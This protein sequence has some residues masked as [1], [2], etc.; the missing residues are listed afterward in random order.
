[1]DGKDDADLQ[2]ALIQELAAGRR[3]SKIPLKLEALAG[4]DANH[5]ADQR[6]TRMFRGGSVCLN[7]DR[8][9][10]SGSSAGLVLPIWAC[11]G[12]RA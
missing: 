9:K 10:I 11:P 12:G 6:H 2:N 3:L 1:M 7:S 5:F 8:Q 4:V